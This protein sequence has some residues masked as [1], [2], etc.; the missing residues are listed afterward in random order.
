MNPRGDDTG[1]R[2]RGNHSPQARRAGWAETSGAPA[3]RQRSSPRPGGGPFGGKGRRPLLSPPAPV[4]LWCL[5]GP[6]V[7]G[8]QVEGIQVRESQHEPL[9]EERRQEKHSQGLDGD[10]RKSDSCRLHML[11]CA[12]CGF[13]LCSIYES[14]C[15]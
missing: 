11:R 10:G 8:R 5:Q 14:F 3:G 1:L 12:S 9:R 6:N 4:L 15:I 7:T 2:T 13:P